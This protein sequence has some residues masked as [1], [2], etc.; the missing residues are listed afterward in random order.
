MTPF[1]SRFLQ[2]AEYYRVSKP[3]ELAKR[4]GL[5]HQSASVYL[6]GGSNIS[7]EGINKI[8]SAFPQLNID[9]LFTGNGEMLLDELPKMEVKPVE[10]S[11]TADLYKQLADVQAKLLIQMEMNMK[12]LIEKYGDKYSKE[13]KETL[14]KLFNK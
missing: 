1:D 7:M 11:D 2:F 3:S 12:M 4:T 8:K 10:K 6:K 13:D 5:T 9:W 14:N